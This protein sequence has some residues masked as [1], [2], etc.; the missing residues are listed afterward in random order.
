MLNM[1]RIAGEW[2][3]L[4]QS[5]DNYD[6]LSFWVCVCV[7]PYLRGPPPKKTVKVSLWYGC[8]WVNRA[9]GRTTNNLLET[10]RDL[11]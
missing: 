10:N 5:W 1:E 4:G 11:A 8:D 6:K 3:I 2:T 9:A 7:C